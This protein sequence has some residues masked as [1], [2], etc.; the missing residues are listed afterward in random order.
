MT[1]FSDRP[2]RSGRPDRPLSRR[3]LPRLGMTAGAVSLASACGWDG[4]ALAPALRGAARVNDWVGEK[5]FLSKRHLAHQYPVSARTPEANFPAYSIAR[6]L[7][8]VADPA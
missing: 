8:R 6:P 1:D 7:P 3:D 5:V 4:A 2:D